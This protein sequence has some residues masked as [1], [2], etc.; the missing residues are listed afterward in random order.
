[1][2]RPLCM[3]CCFASFCIVM[4]VWLFPPGILDFSAY[5]GEKVFITGS[6]VKKELR[7]VNQKETIVI[8]LKS[9]QNTDV[10]SQTIPNQGE[11]SNFIQLH[12]LKGII[13]Y[14]NEKAD[15]KIGEK[16]TVCGTFQAFSRPGNPGEFD[17]AL[18]YAVSGYQGR[19]NQAEVLHKKQNH[20]GIRETLY[21]I[22]RSLE[23][24]ID[25]IYCERD[26]GL[27]KAILLGSQS[28][29]DKELKELYQKNG[30]VHI[31]AISGLHISVLG[32]GLYSLLRRL[33][34]PV[35]MASA[36]SFLF[37]LL[38]SVM[39][40]NSLSVIRAVGMF[41]IKGLSRIWGRTYDLLT[42]AALLALILLL[43]QPLYAYHSGYW[44][45]FGSVAGIGVIFPV[46]QKQ[47]KIDK[48]LKKVTQMLL[49]SLSVTMMTVPVTL[50]FYYEIPTYSILLNL[51]VI[52][53]MT[54]V[55]VL[56]VGNLCY[57]S[58]INLVFGIQNGRL[59]YG[60]QP[61]LIP[62]G[63][64]GQIH[65]LIFEF[66]ERICLWGFELPANRILTGRPALWQILL[67]YICLAGAVFLLDRMESRREQKNGLKNKI[68]IYFIAA[69]LLLGG[70]G[71]LLR[72]P[73]PALSVTVL[74][75]GQGNAG[76]ILYQDKAIIIDAGSSSRKN[77][78]TD[79][80]IPFLKYY[81][82]SEVEAVFIT[83]PDEDHYNAVLELAEHAPMEGISIGKLILPRIA[84]QAIRE[85][86]GME[87]IRQ[88]ADKGNIPITYMYKGMRLETGKLTVTCV[89]PGQRDY[90]MDS[91][92]YSQ[93][94]VIKYHLFSMAFMG[95]AYGEAEEDAV[96]GM[97]E[98][99]TGPVS[100]LN[101]GHHGSGN[102]SQD[103]ALSYLQPRISVIS[104]GKNNFYGHPH[105]ETLTRLEHVGSETFITYLTG[106]VTIKTDGENLRIEKFRETFP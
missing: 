52:P 35:T 101:V 11:Q 30:I 44:L 18:F 86:K 103:A 71:I 85:G 38:Y 61:L 70:I 14:L 60:Q 3:A 16:V 99:L 10:Y 51:F 39:T 100:V 58:M 79:V 34:V 55:M 56:G 23:Q 22:R 96:K 87:K 67:Y 27:M 12:K 9:V 5:N 98:M 72:H 95:D 75:I 19:V 62:A 91:N 6:I 43:E 40:G 64:I 2:K 102:A 54:V 88:T 15:C 57:L 33:T 77:T 8:Y 31:L 82:V 13:C 20:C 90:G 45:S 53:L 92:S 83:H 37:L 104:C 97:K 36:V 32:M 21:Q 42:A 24:R 50:W 78:G 106:A 76:V 105:K 69:G 28:E 89:H 84:S 93:V 47:I 65:H 41:G 66:F 94:L 59:P 26:A 4:A 80:V 46:L 63:G 17:A 81:G 25:N 29:V 1:M 48:R 68:R 73:R 7:T 74:D 49:A